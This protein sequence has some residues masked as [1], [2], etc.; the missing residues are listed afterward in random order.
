MPLLRGGRTRRIYYYYYYL[1]SI[2]LSFAARRTQHS[3]AWANPSTRYPRLLPTFFA[4]VQRH[5]RATLYTRQSPSPPPPLYLCLLSVDPLAVYY[6]RARTVLVVLVV[7]QNPPPVYS[8]PFGGCCWPFATVCATLLRAILPLLPALLRTVVVVPALSRARETRDLATASTDL[9]N[10]HLFD[11]LLY[12]LF[13]FCV[14]HSKKL[15]R[16]LR[17]KGLFW[18]IFLLKKKKNNY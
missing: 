16:T 17:W 11:V 15:H 1:Y 10:R 8:R 14:F 4:S 9:K 7:V 3:R 13:F 18:C 5:S 12:A 2:H 6:V